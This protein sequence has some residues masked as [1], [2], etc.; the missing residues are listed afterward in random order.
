MLVRDTDQKGHGQCIKFPLLQSLRE[1]I[2]TQSY[3]PT[4]L[5]P[6]FFFFFFF[7]KRFV[8]KCSIVAVLR[9]GLLAAIMMSFK[10]IWHP[11][12]SENDKIHFYSQQILQL[13]SWSTLI[14]GEKFVGLW[15]IVVSTTHS[16]PT[17]Q[18]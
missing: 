13:L 18:L 9:C 7:L 4:P 6:Q 15:M 10:D 14:D 11:S 17:Q 16:W 1:V 2:G 3:P 5:L 12:I 8:E